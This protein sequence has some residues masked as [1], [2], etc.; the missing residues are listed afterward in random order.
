[1]TNPQ[2]IHY[3]LNQPI[4]PKDHSANKQPESQSVQALSAILLNCPHHI[5]ACHIAKAY[6]I[7][8]ALSNNTPVTAVGGVRLK[9]RP[10]LVR[11]KLGR[12]YRLIYRLVGSSKENGADTHGSAGLLP[13]QVMTRQ[14]FERELKR[15]C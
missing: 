1:M 5:P 12:E 14:A 3:P 15:R 2:P 13:I 7:D 4:S 8:A 6:E 11:F 10:K 9:C